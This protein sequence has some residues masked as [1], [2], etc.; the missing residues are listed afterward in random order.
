MKMAKRLFSNEV[1]MYRYYL[2]VMLGGPGLLGLIGWLFGDIPP[3]LSIPV[4][5]GAALLAFGLGAGAAILTRA[6]PKGIFDPFSKRFAVR[7][8]ERKL[9][10]RLGIRH[11]KDKIP[12][13][14]AL[15]GYL[16]KKA[17]TDREDN[18]YLLHFMTETCYAEFM[19]VACV[20]VGFLILIPALFFN[21]AYLFCIALPVAVIHGI[22]HFLPV[23]V[24]R[25]VRPFLM[26]TYLY[27]Q[28]KAERLQAQSS[29]ETV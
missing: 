12:E 5:Y 26:H 27:N 6:L 29:I 3:Y 11:W 16:S 14:G 10:V 25:Y 4:A 28:K 17:V 2:I 1:L 24:Q 7:R 13:T 9:L 22:L 19:H 23:L 18:A 15:L 20:L 8:W 21:K